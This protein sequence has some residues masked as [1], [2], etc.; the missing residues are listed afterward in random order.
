MTPK[1]PKMPLGVKLAA[2]LIS[3]GFHP[4]DAARAAGIKL[5][6]YPDG[7]LAWSAAAMGERPR[8]RIDFDHCPALALRPLYKQTAATGPIGWM[9]V[10]NDPR[11]IMP[12]GRAP[13][14]VKTKAD[15]TAAAKV[16]RL[17]KK[18]I[19]ILDPGYAIRLNIKPKRAWPKG[20][21][22]ATRAK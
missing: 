19:P 4:E 21:K 20:R 17:V 13:H 11:W 5:P 18:Q 16:K 15:T 3:I 14:A 9:P 10:S 8:S 7:A 6:G 2:C 1:R 12:I 22:I